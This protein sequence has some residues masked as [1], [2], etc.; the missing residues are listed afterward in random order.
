MLLAASYFVAS[1]GVVLVRQRTLQILEEQEQEKA[2]E[3]EESTYEP[4]AVVLEEDKEEEC[5]ACEQSAIANTVKAYDRHVII[6]GYVTMED[7]HINKTSPFIQ[8]LE[9]YLEKSNL[10]VKITAC[11]HP[12]STDNFTDVIIYPEKLVVTLNTE[13]EYDIECL[14][15]WLV[16]PTS[17]LVLPSCSVP[18]KKLILVCRHAA[19]DK[20]CG[21]IGPQVISEINSEIR[22]RGMTQFDVYVRGSTHL[23]G[24]EWASIVVVYP[25]CDWY[26]YISKRNVGVLIDGV[27]SG[28]RL[29]KCYRGRGSKFDW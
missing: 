6:C 23:G 5:E 25:E 3:I 9:Q 15:Q 2:I 7:S 27:L 4:A 8:K 24:H 22:S 12:N 28:K 17:Q 21:K 20:R 11:D 14:A 26:G 16:D 19:R 13:S 10:A 18:W 29:E 1:I